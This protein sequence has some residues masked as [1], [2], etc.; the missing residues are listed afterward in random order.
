MNARYQYGPGDPTGQY[1]AAMV[2]SWWPQHHVWYGVNKNIHRA[3]VAK[4]LSELYITLT[5]D[6]FSYSCIYP[7]RNRCEALT[8]PRSIYIIHREK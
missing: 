5:K 8:D 7:F 6:E 4:I 1:V 3:D 2:A